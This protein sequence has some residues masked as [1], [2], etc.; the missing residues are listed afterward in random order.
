MTRW[1]ALKE[2]FQEK[3]RL[4]GDW[5]VTVHF[6]HPW[7][8]LS[9]TIHSTASQRQ[10]TIHNAHAGHLF[11]KGNDSGGIGE[12]IF[13]GSLAQFLHHRQ[14][15]GR[16][17][18]ARESHVSIWRPP[19]KPNR[20][21]SPADSFLFDFHDWI[22]RRWLLF[23]TSDRIYLSAKTLNFRYPQYQLVYPLIYP[24]VIYPNLITLAGEPQRG[25]RQTDQVLFSTVTGGKWAERK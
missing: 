17:R 19:A 11:F 10:R 20:L 5:R 12:A 24:K 8:I 1:P 9:V 25:W 2:D 3:P 21:K 14:R 18:V 23:A 6:G 22:G 16:K 4:R 13:T 15:C 7:I